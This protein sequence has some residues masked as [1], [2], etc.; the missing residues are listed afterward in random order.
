M[1]KKFKKGHQEWTKAC[2]DV[3]LKPQKISTPIK[4]RFFNFGFNTI[5]VNL[6]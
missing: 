1:P 4:S 5:L 6:L 3:G 2:I